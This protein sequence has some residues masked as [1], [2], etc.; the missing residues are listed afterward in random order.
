[1]GFFSKK[2]KVESPKKASEPP[3]FEA[4]R[5]QA[6]LFIEKEKELD[7]KL[8]DIARR[9]QE[10]IDRGGELPN[11]KIPAPAHPEENK[12]AHK[13]KDTSLW[14]NAE[15]TAREFKNKEIELEEREEALRIA[16][17]SFS[18]GGKKDER[19]E[20]VQKVEVN[21]DGTPIYTYGPPPNI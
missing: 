11:R 5:T 10:F 12:K 2:K 3:L 1:M 7:K 14:A 20:V 18:K 16:E 8:M 17:G 6:E 21:E 13:S 19:V 4:M 15:R 9:E